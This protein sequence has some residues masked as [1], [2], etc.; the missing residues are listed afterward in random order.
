MLESESTVFWSLGDEGAIE[1]SVLPA[2]IPGGRG[3]DST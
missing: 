2:T 1:V 3:I